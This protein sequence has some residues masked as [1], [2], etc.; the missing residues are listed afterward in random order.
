MRLFGDIDDTVVGAFRGVVDIYK[1]R[2]HWYARTWPRPSTRPPTDAQ[3]DSQAALRAFIE[4]RQSIPGFYFEQLAQL[5]PPP[6]KS[7]DDQFRY[8]FLPMF[9]ALEISTPPITLE[10]QLHKNP[11][12]APWTITVQVVS[13]P[14]YLF[15]SHDWR[16]DQDSPVPFD[17]SWIPRIIR[18]P[19]DN[20][21]STRY[22]LATKT[23][24]PVISSSFNP[25]NSTWTI[26]LP[27]K[28]LPISIYPANMFPD[29][30]HIP[31]NLPK[32]FV[33]T[34]P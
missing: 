5:S 26:T 6:D 10:C 18:C 20:A 25:I 19:R 14:A 9:H 27:K 2:G 31:L 21:I 17:P 7:W 34:S 28:T 12:P 32:S 30:I 24:G 8:W 33:E 23:F 11:D 1:Q 16:I 15:S 4:F 3:L 13:Y 29:F 22:D